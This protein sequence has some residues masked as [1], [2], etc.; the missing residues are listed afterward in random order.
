MNEQFDDLTYLTNGWKDGLCALTCFTI[1]LALLN[2]RCEVI[3]QVI[4]DLSC[5]N[6]DFVLLGERHSIRHD[7]DVKGEQTSILLVNTN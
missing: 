2:I 4:D 5:E 1:F 7:F 6:L 3:E